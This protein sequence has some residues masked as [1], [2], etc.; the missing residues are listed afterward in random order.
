VH[1]EKTETQNEVHHQVQQPAAI[2]KHVETIPQTVSLPQVKVTATHVP[3]KTQ[4]ELSKIYDL[5][6]SRHARREFTALLNLH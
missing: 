2:D 4:G 3:T 6:L 1:V 5:L